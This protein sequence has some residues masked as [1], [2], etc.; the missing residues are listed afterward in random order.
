MHWSNKI[1]FVILSAL[2]YNFALWFPDQ[3]HLVIFVFLIP[4]YYGV[5]EPQKIFLSVAL[6][7]GFWW[8]IVFWTGHL[9]YFAFLINDF[10]SG[11]FRFFLYFFCVFYFACFSL[12]WFFFAT[13]FSQWVQSWISWLTVSW[14]Y[15]MGIFY[16]GLLF[17]GSCEGYPFSFPL[18]VLAYAKIGLLSVLGKGVLLLSLLGFQITVAKSLRSFSTTNVGMALLCLIPFLI[19][20]KACHYL[21]FMNDRIGF[22]RPDVSQN[23]YQQLLNIRRELEKLN[24]KEPN[25]HMLVAPESTFP[26]MVNECSFFVPLLQEG[27]FPDQTFI[28]GA[29]RRE[30]GH[31]YNCLCLLH[32]GRITQIYDKKHLMILTEKV[33]QIPFFSDFLSSFFLSHSYSFEP[34]DPKGQNCM[35]IAGKP[36]TVFMCSEF[37]IPLNFMQPCAK[38]DIVACFVNDSWFRCRYMKKL[39]WLYA[40][41][42]A[43]E[44]QKCVLYVSHEYGDVIGC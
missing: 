8:G 41:L 2:L 24:Q 5:L 10:A 11:P 44:H 42:Y 34:G 18:L 30:E 21:S 17:T 28:F 23:P 22:I 1:I 43:V 13:F 33:P 7:N 15:F 38:T 19:P 16:C 25:L 14:L 20:H 39:L 26:F 3:C 12:L 37:F 36:I 6:K 35:L 40:H 29:H 9:W 32:Q 4:L 31:C 27:M